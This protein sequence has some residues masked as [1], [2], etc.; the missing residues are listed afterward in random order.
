VSAE[1][2]AWI[3][4]QLAAFGTIRSRR[5]FSGVGLY[6]DDY[7]FALISQDCLYFKVD[8]SN[9]ADYSNRN[10]RVFNPYGDGRTMSYF[11]VPEDVIEDTDE[12]KIWARKALAVAMAETVRKAARSKVSTT[13]VAKAK[14]GARAKGS[15]RAKS[16]TKAKVGSKRQRSAKRRS[17]PR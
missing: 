9:R 11:A 7:F 12:L 6:A 5:M 17:S 10:C 2:L 3:L 8:D 14:R 4:D 16:S 1:Y 15:A 13:A